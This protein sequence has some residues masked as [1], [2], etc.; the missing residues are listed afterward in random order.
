VDSVDLYEIKDSELD[1]LEQGS[2]ATLCLNFAIFL[3]SLAF[4]ALGTLATATTFRHPLVETILVV[5]MVVGFVVGLFLLLM[6]RR[7]RKSVTVVCW[8][9]R[10]RITADVVSATSEASP[11]LEIGADPPAEPKG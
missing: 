5:I 1:L 9:I 6:W 4:S 8:S 10:R 11:S 2:P 3:L 7:D